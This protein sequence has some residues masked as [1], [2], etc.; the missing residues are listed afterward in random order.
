MSD[1]AVQLRDEL[2]GIA[3]RLMEDGDKEGH[4]LACCVAIAIEEVEKWMYKGEFTP[5]VAPFREGH[6][7]QMPGLEPPEMSHPWS[8]PSPATNPWRWSPN[9]N[10]GPIDLNKLGAWQRIKARASKGKPVVV[11][12]PSPLDGYDPNQWDA[13]TM[14]AFKDGN[15]PVF[16][17]MIQTIPMMPQITLKQASDYLSRMMQAYPHLW[18]ENTKAAKTKT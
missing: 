18:D 12:N 9:R 7:F 1:K 13:A 16:L 14:Q 3:D 4:V 5:S 6:E 11:P 10:D 15:R 8:P 17:R 2:N